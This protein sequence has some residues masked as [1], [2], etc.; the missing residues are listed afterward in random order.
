MGKRRDRRL[1]AL[2]N[3]GRRVKLDLFAEPSGDL[4]ASS[5]HDEV[6]GDIDP[7]QRA[8]VPN[9]PSSSGQQPQNPLLLL[10]QYSDDEVDEESNKIQNHTVTENSPAD[11]NDQVTCW[12]CNYL[13][14]PTTLSVSLKWKNHQLS[15]ISHESM[16]S[17][18]KISKFFP[19]YLFTP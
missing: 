8:G 1:A 4:G 13:S 17:C 3:A 12:F 19:G 16:T 9:S 10:G 18:L 2:N 7:T 5:V 15:Y 14:F 11:L 6:G